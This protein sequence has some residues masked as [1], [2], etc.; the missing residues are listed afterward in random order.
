M[1]NGK[2]S[3]IDKNDVIYKLVNNFLNRMSLSDE[4]LMLKLIY[5]IMQQ[6]PV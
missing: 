4:T 5:Q 3:W 1:K 6:K 2:V